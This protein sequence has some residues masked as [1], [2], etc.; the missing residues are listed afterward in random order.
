MRNTILNA[1]LLAFSSLA[2]VNPQPQPVHAR[3]P[4]P[5]SIGACPPGYRYSSRWCVPQTGGRYEAVP[6]AGRSCP[7][8]WRWRDNYCIRQIKSHRFI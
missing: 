8:G 1:A 2:L 3:A 7:G 6:S 5:A 4:I